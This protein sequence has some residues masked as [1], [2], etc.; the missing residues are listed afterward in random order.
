MQRQ[1]RILFPVYV[2]YGTDYGQ[3]AYEFNIPAILTITTEEHKKNQ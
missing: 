1:G 2:F 3:H